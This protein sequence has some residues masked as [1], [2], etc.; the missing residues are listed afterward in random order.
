[1]V[2]KISLT[3]ATT[4]GESPDD[5]ARRMSRRRLIWEILSDLDQNQ[6]SALVKT[7]ED[8]LSAPGKGLHRKLMA[9]ALIEISKNIPGIAKDMIEFLWEK[10][11]AKVPQQERTFLFQEIDSQCEFWKKYLGKV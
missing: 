9:C 6:R 1:M 5:F 10:A 8:Y 11:E 4:G 3:N 7:T 2:D